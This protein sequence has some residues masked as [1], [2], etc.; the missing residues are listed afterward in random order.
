MYYS[1]MNGWYFPAKQVT[2]VIIYF[3]GI[4]M[5]PIDL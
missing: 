2:I 4:T 1:E 5:S 3:N